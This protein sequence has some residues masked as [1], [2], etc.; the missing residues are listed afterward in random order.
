MATYSSNWN[1]G[2]TTVGTS[3]TGYISTEG[4]GYVTVDWGQEEK[5][6]DYNGWDAPDNK[7]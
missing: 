1:T 6:A 7:E 4:Y 3:S 2:Y 5:V